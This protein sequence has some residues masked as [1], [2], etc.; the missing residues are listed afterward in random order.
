MKHLLTRLLATNSAIQTLRGLSD[1]SNSI[2]PYTGPRLT[3]ETTVPDG[4]ALSDK[5]WE[6][7]SFDDL[8]KPK[9]NCLG[10]YLDTEPGKGAGFN[11]I[12]NEENGKA[13]PL[14]VIS[15]SGEAVP[16]FQIL[17][18]GPDNCNSDW[19]QTWGY[20]PYP[21]TD[22]TN[23]SYVIFSD[24]KTF[25]SDRYGNQIFEFNDNLPQGQGTSDGPMVYAFGIIDENGNSMGT[26]LVGQ[27]SL[28]TSQCAQF[29][30][31]F[32]VTNARIYFSDLTKE[33]INRGCPTGEIEDEVIV[34][35]SFL[36]FGLDNDE[37]TAKS[38]AKG[39]STWML[40]LL[41]GQNALK[42]ALRKFGDEA[43]KKMVEEFDTRLLI[44]LGRYCVKNILQRHKN[45]HENE[46]MRGQPK[47]IS[48]KDFESVVKL[49]INSTIDQL[50][51]KLES[52]NMN[53]E[54]FK[55][56]VEKEILSLTENFQTGALKFAKT[57]EVNCLVRLLIKTLIVN[58]DVWEQIIKNQETQNNV[59][60]KL[61]YELGLDCQTRKSI[62]LENR[63]TELEEKGSAADLIEDSETRRSDSGSD[64]DLS[65]SD[66]DKNLQRPEQRERANSASSLEDRAGERQ[67]GK[68]LL[69]ELASGESQK[70]VAWARI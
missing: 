3:A 36:T 37:V 11:H 26:R 25:F 64:V 22:F 61:F 10:T 5:T 35:T 32:N 53:S 59:I 16:P 47:R 24:E 56:Q 19:S 40:M 28:G 42:Y 29:L 58:S 27:D 46:E 70:E 14:Q 23:I 65:D 17:Y 4:E 63:I 66:D 7:A 34:D 1:T 31:D 30:V 67:T 44:L 41:I 13:F 38:I 21:L 60:T 55:T 48:M 2:T 8:N 43:K 54:N 68:A 15:P 33:Q 20:E 39:A 18:G 57:E 6:H 69:S 52:G 51:N 62:T 9:K 45:D 12:I 49:E 50:Y